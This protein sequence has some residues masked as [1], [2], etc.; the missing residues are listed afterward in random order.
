MK[1]LLMLCI[2]VLGL[3]G[4]VNHNGFMTINT[5]EPLRYGQLSVPVEDG[6]I[7]HSKVSYFGR[8]GVVRYI[9]TDAPTVAMD[10][11]VVWTKLADN[12]TGRRGQPPMQPR[13]MGDY[14][15]VR[16]TFFL[17]RQGAQVTDSK[18]ETVEFAGRPG[19]KVTMDYTAYNGL[20]MRLV[21]Y[22]AEYKDDIHYVMFEADLVNGFDRYYPAFLKTVQATKFQDRPCVFGTLCG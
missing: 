12:D 2:T 14:S 17:S 21:A 13:E 11:E 19:F 1:K 10:L 18:V 3:T 15:K 16:Y 7:R 9:R 4:C 6:W 5:Q 8:A 20:E 22:G